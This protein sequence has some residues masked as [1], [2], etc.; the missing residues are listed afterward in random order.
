MYFFFSIFVFFVGQN[1]FDPVPPYYVNSQKEISD[2]YQ[3]P[4]VIQVTESIVMKNEHAE[5]SGDSKEWYRQCEDLQLSKKGRRHR[6]ARIKLL[7]FC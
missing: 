4:S 3:P 5:Y 2:L 1:N 6:D 7:N